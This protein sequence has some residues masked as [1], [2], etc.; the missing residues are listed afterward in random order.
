MKKTILIL[1]ILI[2]AV[3]TVS[4]CGDNG[5]HLTGAQTPTQGNANASAANGNTETTQSGNTANEGQTH[6]NGVSDESADSA[7]HLPSVFSFRLSDTIIA[8]DENISYVITEVGEPQN[9]FEAPSCAFE[10]MDRIYEFPGG[11]Q[12]F[13]YEKDGSDHIHTIAI[14]DDTDLSIRT[15]EGG[16]RMGSSLQDVLDAY[17]DDYYHEADMYTYTRGLTKLSFFIE[18]DMVVAITYELIMQ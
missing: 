16:I 2:F 10:G 15:I 6:E 7:L 4:A 13:T 11:I 12:I 14:V 1:L 5:E 17:G 3:F 18:D 9:V 8:M